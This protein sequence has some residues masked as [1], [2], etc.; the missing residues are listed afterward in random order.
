MS[1]IQVQWGAARLRGLYNRAMPRRAVPSDS[2]RAAFISL[3]LR[4]L[5]RDEARREA[6]EA[7]NLASAYPTAADP[8][9][10]FV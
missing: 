3:W 6:L 4:R 8:S 2:D 9:Y 7:G 10:N 5:G 1:A